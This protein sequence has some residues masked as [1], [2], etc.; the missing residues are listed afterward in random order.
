MVYYYPYYLHFLN[1]FSFRNYNTLPS[2]VT[3]MVS[4]TKEVVLWTIT[5]RSPTT[6]HPY[7]SIHVAKYNYYT[8]N[9]EFMGKRYVSYDDVVNRALQL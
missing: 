6:K 4:P 8:Q 2:N 3:T 7:L 1:L 9:Y 5:R